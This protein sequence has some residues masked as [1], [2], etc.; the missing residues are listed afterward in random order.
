M[1]NKILE[2]KGCGIFQNFKWDKKIPNFVR[3]NLIYG[4]NGSGK[5]TLSKLFAHI[6]ENS[7]SFKKDYPEVKFKIELENEEIINQHDFYKKSQSIKVFNKNFV[8]EN[9]FFDRDESKTNPIIFV[10]KENVEIQKQLTKLREEQQLKEKELGKKNSE[11]KHSKKKKD[12]FLVSTAKKVKTRIGDFKDDDIY[13]NYDKRNLEKEITTVNIKN[14]Q[15]HTQEDCEILYKTI[16]TKQLKEL[17][18]HNKN[19]LSIPLKGNT[20]HGF[21]SISEKIN[22]LLQYQLL[23]KPIEHLMNDDELNKWVEQGFRIHKKR[24]KNK[25]MFCKNE[26]SDDFLNSLSKHFSNEY[27]NFKNEIKSIISK[28]NSFKIDSNTLQK[29]EFYPDLQNEFE[30]KVKELNKS[31][32]RFNSWIKSA[33][34]SLEQKQ[35]NPFQVVNQVEY[36][37]N[38][39][40]FHNASIERYNCHIDKHNKLSQNHDIEIKGAKKKLEHHIIAQEIEVENYKDT[41]L[42]LKTLETDVV[43]I[44]DEIAKIESKISDLEKKNSDSSRV[45]SDI[46]RFLEQ[47]FGRKE[48]HLDSNPLNPK[49]GY[50]IKR[51]NKSANNLSEGEKNAIAFTYFIQKTREKGFNYK[52]G[53]VVID[54]P[55]S[56]L[57]SNSIYMCYS[58]IKNKF[59]DAKQLILLTHNFEFFNLIRY[60][61]VNKS[62][63]NIKK[64]PSNLGSYEIFKIRND[65]IDKHRNASI[66]QIDKTLRQFS[67]EYHYLFWELNSFLEEADENYSSY[68]TI[69][70]IARRF[71]EIYTHFKIPNKRNLRQK[72]DQL[73]V[74]KDHEIAEV[75]I[76]RLYK[77]VNKSSHSGEDFSQVF[78]H[79]ERHEIKHAVES[80]MNIIKKTDSTHYENLNKLYLHRSTSS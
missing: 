32:E 60:W 78:L 18:L 47:Y 13:S 37:E 45:V 16:Q 42:D 29:D 73:C 39:E 53:T 40:D 7:N 14:H 26:F 58:L 59:K 4:W 79:K 44:K 25:C 51:H 41:L 17:D 64:N 43:R 62:D 11:L 19:V 48:I 27:E 74:D 38:F 3:Y 65:I 52:E 1:I 31:S 12:N 56:S 28:L 33:V 30:I 67:S 63:K 57:D 36:P 20:I 61:F 8:K 76:E 23:T 2:L 35:E 24:N 46:N 34:N 49:E 75:D 71:L 9:V 69:G 15:N 10:G 66:S 6:E 68:Y 77:L 72:L 22:D 54:D 70:N 5:T 80:L 50:T 55:V 21:Y